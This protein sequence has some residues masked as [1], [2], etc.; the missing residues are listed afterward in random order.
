MIVSCV[1]H[2]EKPLQPKNITILWT[3]FA[4]K[5][6]NPQR[7]IWQILKK[8]AETVAYLFF[9]NTTFWHGGKTNK[10]SKLRMNMTLRHIRIT[11]VVAK[12]EE[13]L[14]ILSAGSEAC[15]PA[16]KAHALY[17]IVICGPSVSTIFF[18]IISKR[19]NFWEKVIEHKMFVSIFSNTFV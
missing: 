5:I 14:H 17:Y 11:I 16:C 2:M 13:V 15:H 19:N 9:M 4:I 18:H 12:N 3:C 10:R 7:K 1:I 8:S 6:K